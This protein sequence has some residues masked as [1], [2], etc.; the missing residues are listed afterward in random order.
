MEDNWLSID[1]IEY[2]ETLIKEETEKLF[3][4][5]RKGFCDYALDGI[6]LI[7]QG[8]LYLRNIDKLMTQATGISAYVAEDSLY[9]VAKGTGIALE[10]LESY[11][12]SILATK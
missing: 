3:G 11:K 8:V 6:N 2:Q 12:R 5:G 9:C 4:K 10:N 7:I 1:Y